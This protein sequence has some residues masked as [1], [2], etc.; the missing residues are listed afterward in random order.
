MYKDVTMR[1]K[2]FLLLSAAGLSAA[3]GLVAFG[4]AASEPD[5]GPIHPGAG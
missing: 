3:L 5:S 2:N 1:R 4:P